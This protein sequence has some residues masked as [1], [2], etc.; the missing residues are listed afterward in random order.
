VSKPDR[1]G[2]KAADASVACPCCRCDQ[3]RWEGSRGSARPAGGT[4]AGPG[5]AG[6]AR[7]P[8]RAGVRARGRGG[9]K[10]F[11]EIGDQAADLP[12]EIL[13]RLGGKPHPLLRRIIAPSEKRVRTLIHAIGAEILDELIG[14]WLRALADAGRQGGLLT[15]IAID[16]KWLRGV[17]DG[18]VKLFAAMLHENKVVIAQ[19]R[20]PDETTETTQLKELLEPVDLEGAVVTADAAHAQRETADCIAGK[21]E[22]GNRGSD[23]FL[24]VKGNQPSLHKAVFDAIQQDSPREPDHTELDHGHGRIIRRSIWVTDAGSLDFPHV[25]RIARI[26][27]DGY[28][29]DGI[30]ISKEIVHAVTSLGADRA[31][32]ADLARIARG[33]W[34]IESVHWLRDTAWAEDVNTGYAGNGPQVMATLRNLAISLLHLAGVTEI[35]LTLQA[36]ER[37]RTRI[38]N[39]LPL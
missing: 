39:Y 6:A 32:S 10:S 20:I 5:P 24:F 29:L 3:H 27:R 23:Y 21:K 34:G 37:D 14:G 12:Q 25:T 30:L 38:L 8:L 18:Q 1:P 17:A 2:R 15:A 26:R 28:D 16:G 13:A 4:G 19:H 7:T 22:D 36:I 11:R 9:A 35:T 31:S 33:Q